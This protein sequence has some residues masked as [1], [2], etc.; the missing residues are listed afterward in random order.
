[1]TQF[2]DIIE[3]DA[4]RCDG[5]GQCVLDCAEGAIA[6]VDGKAKVV[7]ESFCDGLGACLSG[8]PQ[9]ALAIVRR[10]AP[11]F[12]EEAAMR[13]VASLSGKKAGC[14]G[15]TVR[16]FS[17]PGERAAGLLAPAAHTWPL[18]LR[19]APAGAPFL[20]GADLL[21]AADCSGAASPRFHELAEGRVP[22]IVCPK[23][24][25][26]AEVEARLHEILAVGRPRSL[27]ALRME[28]P[29]CR[30]TVA[31]SETLARKFDIPFQEYMMR[32]DGTLLAVR[33]GAS[34]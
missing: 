15:T 8:C 33:T 34:A 27:T 19:L 25:V 5:C 1:M 32:C 14:P 23:F 16:P 3:I 4:E 24:E 31:L 30:G 9:N 17:T 29:C 22:L 26:R 28:V 21:L 7:S 13:H 18:K 12:D 6:I 2:R 10:E 11:A 20:K